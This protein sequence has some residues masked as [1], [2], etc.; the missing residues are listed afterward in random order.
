MM[1]Q[2]QR[3]P[4][5]DYD[6]WVCAISGNCFVLF[7]QLYMFACEREIYTRNGAAAF[8]RA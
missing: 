3:L 7:V 4:L 5:V 6:D 2:W 1:I 8:H